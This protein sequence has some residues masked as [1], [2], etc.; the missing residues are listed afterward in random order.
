[1]SYSCSLLIY[2]DLVYKING[3]TKAVDWISILQFIKYSLAE[4]TE[5]C[6]SL[7]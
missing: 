2:V 4:E 1:M 5:N 3:F 7:N 6:L